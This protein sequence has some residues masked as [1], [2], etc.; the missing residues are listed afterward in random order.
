ML[1]K[2]ALVSGSLLLGL[3]LASACRSTESS[4][5]AS[6]LKGAQAQGAS[7]SAQPQTLR[8]TILLDAVDKDI[9]GLS[10]QESSEKL[11]ADSARNSVFLLQGLARLYEDEAAE[12]KSA[13][14]KFKALEDAIGGVAKWQELL[15]KADKSGAGPDVKQKL[16]T[17]LEKAQAS[18]QKTLTKEDFIPGSQS[19]TPYIKGFRAFLANYP[20][21]PVVEDRDVVIQKLIAQLDLIKGTAYDFTR[22]EE[23][24]G[25]HE[26]R[27]KLRWFAMEAKS[28]N[29][30]VLWKADASCPVPA[31]AALLSTSIAKSKYATLTPSTAETNPVYVTPCYFVR[32]AKAIDEI[33][34]IKDDTE[35][36]DNNSNAGVAS[37]GASDE[38]QKAVEAVRQDLLQ[39]RVY[40]VLKADLQAGLSSAARK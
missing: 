34:N 28:V 17:N 2:K 29:G 36:E 15:D 37:D 33:G 23:G 1:M 20:W 18:L 31:Y 30:L 12:F 11:L 16:S 8:F 25:I 35:E 39:N 4:G 32:I 22:L 19:K 27:R 24:N 5:L 9:A 21:K 3:S 13:R 7:R 38:A 40:D 6:E 26:F 10:A 14:K